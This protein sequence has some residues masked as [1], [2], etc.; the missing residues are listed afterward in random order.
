MWRQGDDKKISEENHD[1]NEDEDI[2]N[3]IR[4][5]RGGNRK[6]KISVKQ[7]ESNDHGIL[8][9]RVGLKVK[10]EDE[11]GETVKIESLKGMDDYD[12]DEN[13]SDIGNIDNNEDGLFPESPVHNVTV[14]S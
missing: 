7:D 3:K 1:K 8:E 5:S 6:C 2:D 9:P 14:K 4:S 10:A 11:N 13:D 12:L